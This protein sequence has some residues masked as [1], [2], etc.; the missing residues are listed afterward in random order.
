MV[1]FFEFRKDI[2]STIDN[3]ISELLNNSDKKVFC[4]KHCSECCQFT[5]PISLLDL[6]FLLK[7]LNLLND[8]IKVLISKNIDDLK[9]IEQ[10]DYDEFIEKN[11]EGGVRIRCPFLINDACSIYDYRPFPCRIHFST[12]PELCLQNKADSSFKNDDKIMQLSTIDFY[13]GGNFEK[14]TAIFLHE[15]VS[16]NI[17][18][19]QF[20]ENAYNVFEFIN[21]ED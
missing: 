6:K 1:D 12:T 2:F 15:S 8:D 7:G 18:T 14:P 13:G 11:S 20:K 5:F 17:H 10:I 3:T 4:K 9:E 16:F 19:K 21:S